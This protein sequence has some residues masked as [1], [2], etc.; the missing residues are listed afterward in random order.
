MDNILEY[1]KDRERIKYIWTEKYTWDE[2]S[3]IEKDNLI[4]IFVRKLD[5]LV[6]KEPNIDWYDNMYFEGWFNYTTNLH[7]ALN[8]AKILTKN[9]DL[10]FAMKHNGNEYMCCFH[11]ITE[12][13]VYSYCK[14]LEEAICLAALRHCGIKI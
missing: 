14:T 6:G 11:N 2:L 8:I 7:D 5:S 12:K 1:V 3:N 9:N 13:P 4:A 10:Q